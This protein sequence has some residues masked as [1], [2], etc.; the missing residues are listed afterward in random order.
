MKNKYLSLFLLLLVANCSIYQKYYDEAYSIAAAMTLEQKLGQT[1]QLDFYSV[2]DKNGTDP[3][4]ASKLHLGS[5]L[6]DGDGVPDANGNLIFI[7]EN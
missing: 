5:L 1:I 3:A 4:L 7:P 6:L 2:T